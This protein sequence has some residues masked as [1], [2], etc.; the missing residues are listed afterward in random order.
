MKVVKVSSFLLSALIAAISALGQTSDSSTSGQLKMLFQ[1]AGRWKSNNAT[2]Q[3]GGK[4]YTFGYTADFKPVSERNGLIM[5]EHADIPQIGKLN[6]TNLIGVNPWDGKIHWFSVDNLGTSHEHV[7]RFTDRNHF[8][9]IHHGIQ[10]QKEFTE[11]VSIEFEG[12]DTIHIK[13]TEILDGKTEL[14][15]TG[16]FLRKKS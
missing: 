1:L 10:N 4:T 13:Q 15:V 9:M 16:S 6:G 5:E 11:T 14:V 8:S 7:G 12:P 2:L 3:M